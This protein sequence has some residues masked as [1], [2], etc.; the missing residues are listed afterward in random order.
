MT[1]S[2]APRR[3]ATTFLPCGTGARSWEGAVLHLYLDNANYVWN[4][5]CGDTVELR[6]ALNSAVDWAPYAQTPGE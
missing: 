3:V 6:N 4:N 2:G 5:D 1:N